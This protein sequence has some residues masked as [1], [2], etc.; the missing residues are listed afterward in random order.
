[1]LLLHPTLTCT[2]ASPDLCTNTLTFG[3][4]IPFAHVVVLP[5]ATCTGSAMH[6]SQ[7]LAQIRWLYVHP[8]ILLK[9]VA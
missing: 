9:I 7:P 1:M 2:D 5:I 6:F 8:L 3:T 4:N